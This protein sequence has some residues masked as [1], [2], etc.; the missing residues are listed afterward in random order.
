MINKYFCESESAYLSR[1]I[2]SAIGSWILCCAGDRNAMEDESKYGVS[3]NYILTRCSEILNDFFEI[4]PQAQAWF[5]AED[6]ADGSGVIKY[7]RDIYE[8]LGY[9]VS[10]GPN[11]SLILP[12]YHE[13]IIEDGLV[14]LRGTAKLSK[15]IGLG[16]YEFSKREKENISCLFNMFLIPTQKADKYVLDHFKKA[17]WTICGG[18]SEGTQ[19][20]D[21]SSRFSLSKSWI[22]ICNRNIR[23]I[24]KNNFVDFGLVKSIQGQLYTSQFPKHIFEEHE[25]RRF[26][27]GLKGINEVSMKA[28]LNELKDVAVLK[29]YSALPLKE[30]FLLRLLAWPV[31]SI[32][33]EYNY[34]VP[35]EVINV[36]KMILEN[37]CIDVEGK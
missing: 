13:V 27:Y 29:L 37:L 5:L 3:K 11:T 18:V 22:D 20:F 36:V 30:R 33:D 6:I 28:K 14:L 2:Y 12:K 17:K 9:L 8:S 31:N 24:Y 16:I 32:K 25:V 23:T 26:M 7:I 1:L 10:A 35:L 4:C 19:F 21:Y 15:M 34:Y